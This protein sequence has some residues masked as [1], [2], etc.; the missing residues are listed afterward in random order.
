MTSIG[1]SAPADFLHQQLGALIDYD[2]TH[3]SELV[4]TRAVYLDCG[5]NYN[6]TARALF[7]HRSTLR[8]RLRRIREVSGYDLSDVDTRL[9]LHVAT[10]TWVVF[11]DPASNSQHALHGPIPDNQ[12]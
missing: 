6:N 3:R 11:A 2:I 5:G 1:A 12:P 10:R 8:Y 7:I 4:K 9:N